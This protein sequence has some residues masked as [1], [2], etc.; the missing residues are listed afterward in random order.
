MRKFAQ[1]GIFNVT[2]NRS[3]KVELLRRRA[4]LFSWFRRAKRGGAV[5]AATMH[6]RT[7]SGGQI[8][9]RW[10]VRGLLNRHRHSKVNLLADH[11]R[12]T[13]VYGCHRIP[14]Y[15]PYDQ[16]PIVQSAANNALS[17]LN[18]LDS[19]Y[20][21]SDGSSL[22]N[23]GLQFKLA[24]VQCHRRTEERGHGSNQKSA[25]WQQHYRFEKRRCYETYRDKADDN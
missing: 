24:S 17:H 14:T 25:R 19:R 6:R 5:P 13:Q 11:F 8:Q 12:C 18:T 22:N 7:C 23:S 16:C 15:S 4:I 20:G 1:S 10:L 9:P 3:S 21:D 2:A